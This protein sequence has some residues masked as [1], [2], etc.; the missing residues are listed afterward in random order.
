MTADP[1]LPLGLAG[2]EGRTWTDDEAE[3]WNCREIAEFRTALALNDGFVFHMIVA[4]TRDQVRQALEAAG[5]TAPWWFEPAYMGDQEP[6]EAAQQLL[7]GLD[8]L[9]QQAEHAPR[10]VVLNLAGRDRAEEPALRLMFRIL[11][12]HRDGIRRQVPAPFLL[13]LS[14]RLEALFIAEAP[15]FRAI[16]SSGMRLVLPPP[17]LS[18]ENT[19][20]VAAPATPRFSPG[21]RE[22]LERRLSE[23]RTLPA[24]LQD[25][26]ALCASLGESHAESAPERALPFLEEAAGYYRAL[27]A[28]GRGQFRSNLADLLLRV[29]DVQG[30]LGAREA[31][32]AATREAVEI[33]RALAAAQPDAFRPALAG[34]LNNVGNRLSDLGQREAALAAAREATDLYRSLAA[35]RPDAFRPDLAMSL[36]NLGAMLAD[37]GER[38]AA[39]AAAREAVVLYTDLA[40]RYPQA[41]TQHLGISARSL[42]TRLQEADLPIEGDPMLQAAEAELAPIPNAPVSNRDAAGG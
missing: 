31:A 9:F 41:F 38:E 7:R 42:R 25:L 4:E 22:G 28:Q 19:L 10:P 26:A 18:G 20:A 27:I 1:A 17:N 30:A 2:G 21:N 11:N 32:L 39:L 33:H 29:G 16:R 12:Q 37:L 5:V 34:S 24:P 6:L 15:D 40:R 14:R 3:T 23:A 13:A 8:A 35:A 36:N